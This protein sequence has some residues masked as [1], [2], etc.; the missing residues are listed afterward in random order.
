[1]TREELIKAVERIHPQLGRD[2]AAIVILTLFSSMKEAL[3]HGEK[4]EIRGFEDECNQA[5]NIITEETPVEG[6]D[7]ADLEVTKVDNVPVCAVPGDLIR[8][9][10][11]YTNN[12][13]SIAA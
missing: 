10:I 7:A 8:Y 11:S 9:T 5:N 3:V 1:M 2:E 12:S 13:F 4:V 6:A